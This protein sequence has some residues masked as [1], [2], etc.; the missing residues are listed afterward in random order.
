MSSEVKNLFELEVCLK[1]GDAK[2]FLS[3][4]KKVIASGREGK[5]T[6]TR[7]PGLTIYTPNNPQNLSAK[8]NVL[9]LI[10]ELSRTGAPVVAVDAAKALIK[11]GY[12]VT[13]ITMRRGPLLKELL[14][15]GI[16]VVFDRELEITHD[17]QMILEARNTPMYIDRFIKS[18]DQ[19]IVVTAV[20]YNLIRRLN[21]NTKTPI[22]WWLHEGTATYDNLASLMPTTIIPPIQV[23]TG[24]KYALDQLK[25]YNL[26]YPAKILN[27]GLIDTFDP[28][29]SSTPHDKV[30][31]ILPG[32]IGKRKG[33]KIL[34]DA[35]EILPPKYQKAANFT[36]IGDIVSEADIDGK[37]TKN[38]LLSASRNHA[39]INYI[40]SVT[41]EELFDLYKKT[42]VLVL[43][44]LDDPMPVV[45]TEALMLEKIVLC[46][47]TT[48]TSY[49]LK[50]GKNGFIFG[51]GSVPKLAEK[52][53]YIIDHKDDL[54]KIG[55]NGRQVYLQNFEM[56]IFENNLLN[57]MKEAA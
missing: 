32:S 39:N 47:D 38:A 17:S 30:N 19:V 40:T 31:F 54:A 25:N 23:Y 16:P 5:C 57:I 26:F 6:L 14:D 44:S 42:D 36:F 3:A 46:S 15:S 11:N 56:G 24:G 53:Q 13:V 20:Y 8:K 35:I 22:V 12:F 7:N 10:H 18:F 2:S 37:N 27:Y 49:Y 51:S 41:R 45:A 1:K 43:P 50:D 48:G 9:L 29:N 55:K 34:L 33:Q 52:I 28:E 4:F 21:N